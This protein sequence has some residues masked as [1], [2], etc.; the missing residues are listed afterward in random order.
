[1]PKKIYHPKIGNSTL[2]IESEINYESGT[3]FFA[4]IQSVA[5]PTYVKNSW[6]PVFD[7]FNRKNYSTQV[8]H[9]VLWGNSP[10]F[11]KMGI[12]HL[13]T[14]KGNVVR[15]GTPIKRF[16]EM[17]RSS[18]FMTFIHKEENVNN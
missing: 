9:Y 13:I 4:L 16:F 7:G 5:K 2:L 3:K 8:H 1:M 10:E 12:T 6:P 17:I 14:D 11:D 18:E 15:G